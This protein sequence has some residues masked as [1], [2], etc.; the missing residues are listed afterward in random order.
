[1][2][3]RG[4]IAGEIVMPPGQI[5]EHHG[6][7]HWQQRADDGREHER[8]PRSGG[9]LH[10]RWKAAERSEAMKDRESALVNLLTS[11]ELWPRMWTHVASSVCLSAALRFGAKRREIGPKRGIRQFLS[12]VSVE[13][14]TWKISETIA[15]RDGTCWN[16]P[17]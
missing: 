11:R 2:E 14:S 12:M 17:A 3:H 15:F 9:L 8:T 7:H 5:A 13:V 16:R 4:V 1:V 6:E 10:V